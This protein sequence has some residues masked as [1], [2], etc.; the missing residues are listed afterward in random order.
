MKKPSLVL[1]H[2]KKRPESTHDAWMADIAHQLKDTYDVYLPRVEESRKVGYVGWKQPLD[3]LD[4]HI[5]KHAIPIGHSAGAAVIVR[6]LGER[7]RESYQ[8]T[9]PR[10]SMIHP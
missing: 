10:S 3:E 2:G 9:H 1:L 6:R 4:G 8:K 5:D 7:E